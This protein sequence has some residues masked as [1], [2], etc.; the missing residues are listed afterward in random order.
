MIRSIP[1]EFRKT[2]VSAVQPRP[3]EVR[4]SRPQEDRKPVPKEE[5]QSRRHDDRDSRKEDGGSQQ[6]ER[7]GRVE[8]PSKERSPSLGQNATRPSAAAGSNPGESEKL[9]QHF[10]KSCRAKNLK[11]DL[12]IK[13]VKFWSLVG[14][15]ETT[16]RRFFEML[17]PETP[18]QL[19]VLLVSELMKPRSSDFPDDVPVEFLL[20]ETASFFFPASTTSPSKVDDGNKV[21]DPDS[22]ET[23]FESLKPFREFIVTKMKSMAATFGITDDYIS[24]VSTDIRRL[25]AASGFGL[26]DMVRA[27]RDGQTLVG[28]LNS[29]MLPRGVTP[30]FVLRMIEEFVANFRSGS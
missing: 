5:R 9:S 27:S 3:Q 30:E 26:D 2:T 1:S 12:G 7:H 24:N 29:A 13:M 8:R 19:R 23:R 18:D 14:H 28:R 21:G 11:P 17:R 4:Q 10:V 20:S 22:E 25:V 15:D 16:L 6:R